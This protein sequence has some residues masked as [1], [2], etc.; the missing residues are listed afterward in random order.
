M[1]QRIFGHVGLFHATLLTR[2]ARYRTYVACGLGFDTPSA[3]SRLIRAW[4]D[5]NFERRGPRDMDADLHGVV[6]FL[7]S[8]AFAVN[9]VANLGGAMGGVLLAFWIERFRARRET[10][11]VYGRIL[12]T[13]HTE[14]A[15]LKPMCEH[16]RDALRAGQ[17][18]GTV[19]SFAVPAT[20]AL[21]INPVVHEQ[22][23][24]SLIEGYARFSKI[25]R[26]P[27]GPELKTKSRGPALA[28]GLLSG[29]QFWLPVARVTTGCFEAPQTAG[30]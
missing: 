17:S 5:N 20:R 4:L 10:K 8:R 29:F 21:L 26:R 2:I 25:R 24:Y 6:C 23:P 12:R 13:S 27:R 16:R 11:M 7:T 28:I 15:Y 3:G 18:A 30:R 14:L 19:D 22:A 9:F 1:V